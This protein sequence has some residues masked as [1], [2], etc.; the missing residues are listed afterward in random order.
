MLIV[1]SVNFCFS[2]QYIMFHIFSLSPKFQIVK[3]SSD[4]MLQFVDYLQAQGWSFIVAP[5]L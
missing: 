3:I 2:P 5:E 4:Q 1:V